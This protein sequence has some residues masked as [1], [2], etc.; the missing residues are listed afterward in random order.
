MGRLIVLLVVMA[1]SS[2]LQRSTM[3]RQDKEVVSM[4][5][6]DKLGHSNLQSP[7]VASSSQPFR[8][9]HQP[10]PTTTSP[11]SYSTTSKFF[12]ISCLCLY[13]F[14]NLSTWL[15]CTH[16]SK[17][18][19]EPLLRCSQSGSTS[20]SSL[21]QHP[22]LAANFPYFKVPIKTSCSP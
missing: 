21:P 9:N 13:R 19:S 12:G 22:S 11:T 3:G 18:P 1:L 15:M 17:C 4:T 7:T 8:I 6:S 10:T 14:L 2:H 5:T 16:F 20:P